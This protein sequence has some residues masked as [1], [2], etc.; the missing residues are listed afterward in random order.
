MSKSARSAR[1]RLASAGFVLPPRPEEEILPLDGKDL[2]DLTDQRL[3]HLLA[4]YTVWADYLNGE[5]AVSEVEENEALVRLKRAQAE[6]LIRNPPKKGEMTIGKADRDADPKVIERQDAHDAAYAYR[7]L[8]KVLYDRVVADAAVV[9]RELTR[10]VGRE[11]P[12][13]RVDGF[14]P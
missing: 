8:M 12:Q 11:A 14:K 5:F 7:K 3:M 9:S 13:R 4:H 6:S 1:S 10:R 2:T